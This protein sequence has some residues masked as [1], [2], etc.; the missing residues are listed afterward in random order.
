MV[1]LVTVIMKEGKQRNKR[2]EQKTKR[3]AMRM[4]SIVEG[5]IGLKQGRT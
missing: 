1:A 3:N 5:H 4:E 2:F